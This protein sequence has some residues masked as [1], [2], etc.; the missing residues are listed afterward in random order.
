VRPA[1]ESAAAI[2]A[3]ERDL[4]DVPDLDPSEASATLLRLLASPNICS[5]KPVFRRY[6]HTIMTN[7]VVAPGEADAAILRVKGTGRG[8]ATAIDCNA[9]YCYLD[10]RL[11]A[12]HAVAE[13]TRNVSCTGATPLAITNCLN[14]GSPEKPAGYYQ[15]RE[16][17]GGMGD[18]CRA[19][20]V[21]VVSGNVSLYNESA[22]GA[23]FPTPTV[24]AVG[25][26]E[27]LERR[28][29]MTW[30]AGDSVALIE[31]AR[32]SIGASE[33]LA[34]I[35]QL[36]AGSPPELDL[37][38]ERKVQAVVRSATEDGL[39]ATAHDCSEGG[40]AVAL[41]E[42]AI[43]SGVGFESDGIVA[44]LG[45]LDAPLFGEAPS[46]IIVSG[47]EAAIAEIEARAAAEGLTVRRLGRAAGD[48]IQLL[49]SVTVSLGDATRAFEHGLEELS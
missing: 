27:R 43:A 18:A 29:T 10:P 15:L 1:A 25:V 4:S 5:R 46:R 34:T 28:A 41:A 48:E 14:F 31:G 36:T 6:D 45:R 2:A 13:A 44:D 23:V 49:E 40:L 19:L 11:G 17:V 33:Y 20:G 16:A 3:R 30:R 8:I 26:I 37:E 7:T 12:A 39:I 9:R 24:G 47:G 22:D 35:H 32:P 38:I 42:M 21:P